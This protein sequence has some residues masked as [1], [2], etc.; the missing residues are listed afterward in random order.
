MI[1]VAATVYFILH[2]LGYFSPAWLWGADMFHYYPPLLLG[3]GV[4][5]AFGV[6]I[7]ATRKNSL[8]DAPLARWAQ[9]LARIHWTT[10]AALLLCL[11]I[12]AWALRVR[13]HYLGDSS[14][15]LANMEILLRGNAE[16]IQWVIGLP[17]AG[18][19]YVPAHQGLDFL[20][21][22]HSYRLGHVLW[23]STPADAYLF[24]SL[25]AGPPYLFVAWKLARHISPTPLGHLTV[26]GLFSTMGT[27]QFFCGYG[28]SYTL[29]NLALAFYAYFGLHRVRGEVSLWHP[30]LCLF[31][32]CSLHLMA[33]SLLPSWIY[34]LWRDEGR[35]GTSLRKPHI[36]PCSFWPPPP[37]FI[38]TLPSIAFTI[39]LYGAQKPRDA[40]L[41]SPLRT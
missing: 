40:T 12:L 27:L 33:L 34:L 32:A 38:F 25:L 21:H 22:Y 16:A 20:L 28:E 31:A 18:L 14:M 30:S 41:C 17:I 2:V 36:A 24:W 3:G 23:N 11:F 4:V 10:G 37:R 15:W 19:E 39:Q 26:F 6:G 7:I 5:A 35:R 8:I 13:G 9:G 29:V 1:L